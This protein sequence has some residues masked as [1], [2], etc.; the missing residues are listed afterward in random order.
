MNLCRTLSCS[1][2]LAFLAVATVTPSMASESE[3][4]VALLSSTS[5]YKAAFE[6][7]VLDE[8]GTI[9]DA[10]SGDV[11]ISRPGDFRWD[12][13]LPFEQ[14][15]ILQG[16]LYYQFDRDVDQLLIQPVDP[17]MTALPNLLLG[18][19]SAALADDFDV[20]YRRESA[21]GGV[22]RELFTLT[23]NAE[24]PIFT[25]VQ[26]TFLGGQLAGIRLSDEFQ[27]DSVFRF[28][29]ISNEPISSDFYLLDVPA[30]TEIIRQ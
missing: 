28:T 10:Y 23:P 27:H 16:G 18:G 7:Q 8:S 26:M 12:T 1:V 2:L 21:V 25:S 24:Q 22:E 11:A 13:V 14:T 30:D 9:I 17:T 5:H 3:R 15:I 29:A 4:L 6:Q 20:V 19:D